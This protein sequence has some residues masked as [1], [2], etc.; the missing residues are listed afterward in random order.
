[1]GAQCRVR[2]GTPGNPGWVRRAGALLAAQGFRGQA[3]ADGSVQPN[4]LA[5]R[6]RRPLQDYQHALASDR[7]VMPVDKRRAGLA[8]WEAAHLI[9]EAVHHARD[10]CRVQGW[11]Q[12][13]HSRQ[14]AP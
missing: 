11:H 9:T 10:V 12:V 1:M 2:R 7:P 14:G 13:S 3:P 6:C 5:A 8:F 4:T